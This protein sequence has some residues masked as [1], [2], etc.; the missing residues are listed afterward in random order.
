MDV[1][2][3]YGR[4]QVEEAR[5]AHGTA[6]APPDCAAVCD[7]SANI[8]REARSLEHDADARERAARAARTCAACREVP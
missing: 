2:A 5:I 6:L 8:D 7:A 4:I 3:V 1:H